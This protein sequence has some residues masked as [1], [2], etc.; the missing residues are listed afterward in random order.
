MSKA[1]VDLDKLHTQLHS[2]SR[3]TL[4]GLLEQAIDLLSKTQLN[5]LI[6]G[7]LD[8]GKLRP[9]PPSAGRLLDVVLEFH[10][11]SLQGDYYEDFNVNSKNYRELSRGTETW[12]AECNRI[13]GRLVQVVPTG[14]AGEVREGFEK[15][16]ELLRL[17]DEGNDPVVFFADEAGSWQV[18]VE[19]DKVI[20]A[21]LRTLALT[22]EAEE[23]AQQAVRII[24][25]F[26]KHRREQ[27]LKAALKLA[28][29]AQ[30]RALREKALPRP[31]PADPRPRSP[32]AKP[33]GS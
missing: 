3:D 31:R 17:I 22:A 24:D 25:E 26:E 16:F 13:L 5:K 14:A 11:A 33:Q 20:P 32:E 7:T 15:I 12:I 6:A 27:H 28:D 18:G 30:K 23:F 4:L 10:Q 1:Q 2:L 9:D 21:W 8:L 19:W 29:P